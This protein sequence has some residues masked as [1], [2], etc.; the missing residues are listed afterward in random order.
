MIP[1]YPNLNILPPDHA[2][3]TSISHFPSL[4][5]LFFFSLSFSCSLSFSSHSPSLLTLLL[6]LTRILHHLHSSNSPRP[7]T[8]GKSPSPRSAQKRFF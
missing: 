7:S 6:Y 4:L 5:T 8:S 1:H 3:P 2:M